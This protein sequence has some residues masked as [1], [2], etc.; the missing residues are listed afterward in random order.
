MTGRPLPPLRFLSLLFGA[1][2]PR[3][4]DEAMASMQLY[5]TRRDVLALPI[6]EAPAPL[7]TARGVTH[8]EAS[9]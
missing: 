6:K 3:E 8:R 5:S 1:R 4:R 9:L 2:A 7:T